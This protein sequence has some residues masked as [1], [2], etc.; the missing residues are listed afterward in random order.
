MLTRDALF[1]IRAAAARSS[2]P[3]RA[4]DLLSRGAGKA[5]PGPARR[6]GP[7]TPV[8]APRAT[9]AAAC[10]TAGRAH[11]R[12][13]RPSVRPDRPGSVSLDGGH[14]NT[15]YTTWLAAQGAWAKAEL[16]KLPKRDEL[17]ARI[18]ELGNGV[19]SVWGI[20]IEHG[21]TIYPTLPAGAQLA[22]LATRDGTAERILIDPRSSDPVTSMLR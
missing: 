16:A 17:F 9:T 7:G 5:D 15:E 4:R 18:R 6:A 21:R 3:R 10:R 13:R 1:R 11:R 2:W 8:V 12:R 22:K 14:R 20:E 19:S